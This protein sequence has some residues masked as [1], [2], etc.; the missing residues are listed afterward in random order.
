VDVV[1]RFG[2]EE[3]VVLLPGADATEACKIAERLREQVNSGGTVVA[4]G[5]VRITVSI[6]V[7]VIGLHGDDIP[8]LL[9][10]ADLAMYRAK[11]AG[12]NQ[13]C[14]RSG[15]ERSPAPQMMTDP[16]SSRYGSG[17]RE[18]APG[19]SRRAGFGHAGDYVP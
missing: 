3:F 4:V 18:R 5:G 15:G 11:A 10:S 16:Q 14:L 8:S 9:T 7:A 1:G 19:G 2:G 13:V 17:G 12:R 6:G